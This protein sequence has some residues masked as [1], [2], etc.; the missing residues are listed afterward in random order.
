[1]KQPGDPVV[2]KSP[3]GQKNRLAERVQRIG[4]DGRANPRSDGACLD[5]TPVP[6]FPGVLFYQE[7]EQ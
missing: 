2:S 3:A 4:G 7:K 1:M 6:S 5:L